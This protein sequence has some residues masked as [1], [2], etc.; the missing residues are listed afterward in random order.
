M[1][2]EEMPQIYARRMTTEHD[3]K[4]TK[5]EKIEKS[6]SHQTEQLNKTP[7]DT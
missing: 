5:N 6:I 3:M 2:A 7:M 4:M 1:L